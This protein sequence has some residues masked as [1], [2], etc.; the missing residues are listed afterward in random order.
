M[1]GRGGNF[2]LNTMLERLPA[3]PLTEMK[4]GEPLIISSTKSLQGQLTAITVVAGVEPFL[5]SAPR[6]AGQVN[7]GAWTF[8]GGVPTQ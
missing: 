1:G 8:D 3:V 7:L 4:P 2:D 6:T 5:A